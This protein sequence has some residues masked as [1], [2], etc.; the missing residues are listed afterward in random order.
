MYMLSFTAMGSLEKIRRQAAAAAAAALRIPSFA[1]GGGRRLEKKPI[2][3][4]ES[5]K[6]VSAAPRAFQ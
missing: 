6:C 5:N 2:F 3:G 4:M 1:G